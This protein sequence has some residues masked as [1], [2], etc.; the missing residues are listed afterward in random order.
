MSALSEALKMPRSTSGALSCKFIQVANQLDE[1][2]QATV[3]AAIE[4]IRND[5]GMGKSKQYSTSWLTK[6]LRS[7]GHD[8][9]MSS[10]QRHVNKECSCERN[11]G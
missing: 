3:S 8:I 2:D 1:E 7:F 6:I 5:V 11:I 9:S 10:V 4:M